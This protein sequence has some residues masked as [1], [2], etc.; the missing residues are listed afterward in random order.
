[1]RNEEMDLRQALSRRRFVQGLVAGGAALGLGMR[2]GRSWALGNAGSPGVLAGTD[3]DLN[4]SESPMNFT[5]RQRTAVTV[6]GSLPAPILRWR[7]GTTVS[8][9]VRNALPA[10]SIHGAQTS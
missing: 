6:N 3:F 5:G 2:A 7:E 1:M 10:G 9:R 4:I 8:V